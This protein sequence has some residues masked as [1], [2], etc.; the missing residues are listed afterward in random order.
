MLGTAL[1]SLHGCWTKP[2]SITDL[3]PSEIH[4]HIF[5]LTESGEMQAYEYRKGPTANLEGV[6]PAF[7]LEPVEYLQAND[8]T[9]SYHWYEVFSD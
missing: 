7:F 6:D 5:R 4:G 1:T 3:R 2:T 9:E 8:L